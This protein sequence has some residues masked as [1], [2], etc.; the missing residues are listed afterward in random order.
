MNED[1]ILIEILGDGTIKVSTEKISEESHLTAE[2]FLS[3]IAQLLGGPVS[4]Q[5]QEREQARVC[6]NQIINR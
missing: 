4:K 5:K 1:Q 3:F 6:N 2:Q